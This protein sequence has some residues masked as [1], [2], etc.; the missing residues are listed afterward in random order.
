MPE[1]KDV[2][3]VRRFMG[4]VNFLG[5]FSPCL[6][7]LTKPIRDLLKTE[8]GWT[9]GPPQLKTEDGWTCGPPL[10]K[11]EDGWT[12]GPPLLKT[13]DGCPI[14]DRGGKQPDGEWRPVVFISR[15]LTK[16]E[17][18]YAQVEKEALALTW[19]CERLR[20]Y[21]SG[22]D[23]TIR[24]NHKPLLTLLK[25]RVLD[26][27]P[28]RI[29]RFRLRLL[30]FNFNIIHVPGKNL[31]TADTLSRTPLPATGTEVEHNLEKECQAY[32][33]SVV[34]S[35][36]ATPTKLD[37]IKSALHS[38]DACKRLSRYIANGWPEHRRNV[39]E[40]LQ[41]YWPDRSCLHVGA[42]LL[43]KD[44]GSNFVK[45]FRMFESQS[46]DGSDSDDLSDEEDVT[47]T[48]VSKVLSTESDETFSLLPH[49]R[50]AFHTLN[51]ISKNDLEKWLTSNNGC[52]AVYR[53]ALAKC[54][55]L[56]TKT[57]RS[58]VASDQVEEV[59]K[60]KLIIP[61][62]THW[63]STHDAL[64]LIIEIPITDLN[65]I[66]SRLGVKCITEREYQFLKEY[67]TVLKPLAAALDILQGEDDCYYG[68]LLPTLEILMLK[69]LALKD[70]LSQMTVG[71]PGAIVQAI[72]S[73][74]SSIL[75]SKDALMAAATMPKFK[76]R[77]LKDE[78][79]RDAVKT[80]LISECRARIPDEPQIRPAA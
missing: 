60:R 20:G 71:M 43:M 45:A 66:C 46:D 3:D 28:P 10:L 26:D 17:S 47:F 21:L 37:Q 48:D 7:D 6:P 11:T 51:L 44:N 57:S 31:I 61:T 75:D 1:P 79:R 8:D 23:F 55:A 65:T 35:L 62:A 16:A 69:L 76:V 36:P 58:T 77:W 5:K 74:F 54:T 18:R 49:L 39:H 34:D 27:L 42:G 52:K 9:W 80:L 19:A 12:W 73:R 14:R 41:P 59:I 64:S 68:T 15:S 30:R 78:K 63:N 24:T 29:I 33:D 40:L 2:A 38:D 32:L 13:E 22:L 25:S 70:G 53:S 72:K 50:C 4:M 67:C 56:W